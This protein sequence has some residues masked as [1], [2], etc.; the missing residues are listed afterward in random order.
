MEY[1][2]FVRGQYQQGDDMV[3]R[4][5]ELMAQ[6]RLAEKL[7]FSDLMSGMHY[8][9]YPL[10]QFQLLPFLSRA[11][12]EAPSMRLVTGIILLSL[13][14]PLD[15]AEQLATIDVMS[16]GRLV[17]GAGLGYRDVEFLGMGTTQKERVPRLVENLEAIKRLWTEENVNMKGSHFELV[18][19]TLS[20]KPL[21]KPLPPIWFGANA[22]AAVRRAAKLADTWFI[23]PHQRMDTIERQLDVYKNALDEYGK[24]FPEELPLMREIFVAKSKEEATRL[25]RPYLEAKYKVY[26]EWGQ[27]KAMPKGDDDLSLDF[28][29]LT[30]DRFLFGSPDEV[31]EQIVGYKKRLGVNKMVLGVHWVGMPQNQ[32]EDTMNMFAEEV[33]PKVKQAL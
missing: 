29:E 31:T 2:F 10:T 7:G 27:D 20:L 28:E 11:M 33:M 13:H 12:V 32:V 5:K 19:C 15:M 22:D 8:A 25:A 16:E 21:Q 30:R 18:D 3:V 4:F 1:G 26:H 6:V 17:F 14:K 23:N 9:G 24:P